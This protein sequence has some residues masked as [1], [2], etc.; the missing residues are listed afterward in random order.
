MNLK[1]LFSGGNVKI[2]VPR[3]EMFF[4]EESRSFGPELC[5][6]VPFVGDRAFGYLTGYI[7]TIGIETEGEI[8]ISPLSVPGRLHN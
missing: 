4:K 2:K 6:E 1:L 8:T 3:M 5:Y 7:K